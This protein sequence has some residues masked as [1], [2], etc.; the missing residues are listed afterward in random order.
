MKLFFTSI[1]FYLK[2][3]IAH[4]RIRRRLR[5]RW[6]TPTASAAP[7]V[8]RHSAGHLLTRRR[9][10]QRPR[11]RCWQEQNV[12]GN[13][14]AAAAAATAHFRSKLLDLGQAK[15]PFFLDDLGQATRLGRNRRRRTR[16][17]QPAAPAPGPW[18]R[19]RKRRAAD[20]QAQRQRV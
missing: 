6:R 14:A 16:S 10:R 12:I 4:R 13:A 7:R 17:P 1:F 9:L 18:Q 8:D 15:L 3:R 20:R 5:R 11:P 2:P 19:R